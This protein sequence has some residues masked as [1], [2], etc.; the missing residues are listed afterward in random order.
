MNLAEE[1][2]YQVLIDG[3][4]IRARARDLLTPTCGLEGSVRKATGSPGRNADIFKAVEDS[5]SSG[6]KA[7]LEII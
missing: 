4:A 5:G 6:R 7:V 3:A 2:S 1:Q